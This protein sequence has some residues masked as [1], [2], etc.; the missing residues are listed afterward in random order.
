VYNGTY[1]EEL[2]IDNSIILEG[3]DK[4]NTVIDGNIFSG[5]IAEDIILIRSNGT[6]V[7][8]FLIENNNGA[9]GNSDDA[10]IDIRGNNNT[11]SNNIIRYCDHYGIYIKALNSNNIISNNT[12]ISNALAMRLEF[13][14]ETKITNNKFVENYRGIRCAR[15][16]HITISNNSINGTFVE[17]IRLE[18]SYTCLISM[19]QIICNA[20]SLHTITLD[21]SN[22]NDIINNHIENIRNA[23]VGFFFT[24]ASCANT[25]NKNVI[26]NFGCGIDL[27]LSS[28]GNLIKNNTIQKNKKGIYFASGCSDTTITQNNITQNTGYGIFFEWSAQDNHIYYNNFNNNTHHANNKGE[29]QWD[30]GRYGNYWDDYEEK[31]PDARKTLRGTWTTPYEIDNNGTDRYPLIDANSNSLKKNN[32]KMFLSYLLK[33]IQN[34]FSLLLN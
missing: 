10:G 12:F 9:G 2:I 1:Y 17:A 27:F 3:E 23:G 24:R 28:N 22:S 31:Y 11:I 25:I 14:S 18:N 29:N 13:T 6:V 7:K 26:S 21:S 4:N 5:Q 30:D 34:H 20:V 16:D 15:V 19:N 32:E 33:Y 8:N